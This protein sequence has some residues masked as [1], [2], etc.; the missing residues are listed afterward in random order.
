MILS[1][2]SGCVQVLPDPAPPA[3]I[4]NLSVD[5]TTNKKW[6][7]RNWQLS[8]AQPSTSL[9]L[10]SQRIA[11]RFQETPD[12]PK[13]WDYVKER[14]WI[15]RLP[16]MLQE[17]FIEQ[18]TNTQKLKGVVKDTVAL[19]ADYLLLATLYE[20]HIDNPFASP[21]FVSLRLLM[22]LRD[23]ETQKIVASKVFW[24][25]QTVL[26]KNFPAFK[27]AFD[28]AYSLLVQDFLDW[29]LTVNLKSKAQTG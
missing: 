8:V 23:N 19:N 26:E 25:K 11:I 17:D 24:Q 13:T 5:V 3:Q 9:M 2:L 20:F 29:I 7:N 27:K 21:A 28:Q 22:Q 18:L 16:S 12:S 1:L 10:D 4:Y 15:E 6:P 14:K